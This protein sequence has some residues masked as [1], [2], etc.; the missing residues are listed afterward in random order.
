ML[1]T[2]AREGF[3]RAGGLRVARALTRKGLR[4]LMYHRFD[5]GARAALERRC[6]YIRKYYNPVAL[7]TAARVWR[8]GGSLPPNALAVTVDDGYRDFYEAAYPVFASFGVPVTVYLVADFM[9]GRCWLWVDRVQYMFERTPL[10]QAEIPL[11]PGNSVVFRLE[12]PGERAYAARAVIEAAKRMPDPDRLTLLAGLPGV[13]KTAVPDEPPPEYAPL[14]WESVREMG[15]HGVE[16]G[17]HT[18]THP[19]LSRIQ[20]DERLRDEIGGSRQ[21]IEEETGKP[22]VHF[23]YPNGRAEDIGEKVLERIR[24]SGFETGVI[25]E[26]GL[27][28]PGSNPLLLK[29]IPAD[30]AYSDLFFHEYLA[31]V[32]RR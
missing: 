7:G 2:L 10:K 23:C 17:P 14:T 22:S 12:S 1:K 28:F 30:P 31:G 21:R 19:I 9:D 8:D 15:S 27:N 5:S 6:A 3:H 11:S 18:R 29:R 32:R 4:I 25:T 16:F 26:E 13:L 24:E 20:D